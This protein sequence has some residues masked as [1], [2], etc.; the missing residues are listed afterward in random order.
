MEKNEFFRYT[1]HHCGSYTDKGGTIN[2]SKFNIT[3]LKKLTRP[4]DLNGTVVVTYSPLL[5][6]L[7]QLH[8]YTYYNNIW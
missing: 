2:F 5:N 3:K 6:G 7:D 1:T 8:V 4:H